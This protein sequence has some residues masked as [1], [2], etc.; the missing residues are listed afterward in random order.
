MANYIQKFDTQ[1]DYNA[2]EHDY[3][4]VSY[5]VSG[6]SLIFAESAPSEF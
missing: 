6:D 3:P 2:A 5:V 1:A 4:N